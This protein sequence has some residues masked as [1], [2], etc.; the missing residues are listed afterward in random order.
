MKI[1][2]LF[3]SIVFISCQQ[4]N[5]S[6]VTVD[7]PIP[8][9]KPFILKGA[10][11]DVYE[12]VD[13]LFIPD[14]S[15]RIDN[16]FE[17][18]DEDGEFSFELLPGD[19]A[20]EIISED[21]QVYNDSI[22]IDNDTNIEVELGPTYFDML[23]LELGNKWTYSYFYDQVTAPID[24][25]T[26]GAITYEI[27]NVTVQ[28]SDTIYTFSETIGLNKITY[29]SQFPNQNLENDTTFIF[30]ENE[31]SLTQDVNGSLS[32]NGEETP[33]SIAFSDYIGFESSRFTN[34]ALRL[35]EFKRYMP[36][37]RVYD[38]SS[39]TY[40]DSLLVINKNPFNLNIGYDSRGSYTVKADVG[41]TAYSYSD[42]DGL[43]YSIGL[44]SFN[45]Q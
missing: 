37:S 13:T 17:Q 15:V 28:E 9:P 18:T 20:L 11:Y 25:I 6:N 30:L 41:I 8:D 2:L 42:R 27:I 22:T 33:I 40:S 10:V 23:P 16:L 43:W 34:S 1:F 19:Y 31:Y 14:I 32:S 4:E 7:E 44:T 12:G 45:G 35:L 3:I 39:N 26:T 38:G 36:K 5:P 24:V 29:S 21:H